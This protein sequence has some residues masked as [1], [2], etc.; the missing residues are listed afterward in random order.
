MNLSKALLLVVDMQR[1]F[2]ESDGVAVRVGGPLHGI[3]AVTENLVGY[4]GQ[5]RREGMRIAYTRHGY[6]PD[7]SDQG[8]S[9]GSFPIS[10]AVRELG[11]VIRGSDDHQIISALA[12]EAGD[13]VIDKVR[14]DAFLHTSL[15]STLR[16]LGVDS[17]VVGGCVT[18]FCVE[19][20]V[21]SAWQRDF[22]VTVL[23]DG[24]AAYTPEMQKRGLDTMA[25][26]C[27][28]MVSTGPQAL[29]RPSTPSS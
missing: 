19:T 1:S 5:A 15:E 6:A 2:C 18:N 17:I 8:R 20:T 28:A 21:R 14:L 10:H 26:C 7:Y 3:E 25:E 24:V 16:G 4:V 9:A 12:P 11:G 27:F 23:A 22:D 13:I 29:L